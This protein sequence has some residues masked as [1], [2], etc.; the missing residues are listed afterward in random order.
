M[1]VQIERETMSAVDN[2]FNKLKSTSAY[3]SMT[4]DQ[5]YDLANELSKAGMYSRIAGIFNSQIDPLSPFTDENS[6]W[7][8]FTY[9]ELIQ[10]EEM[11][12]LIP[13]EVLAWA[14]SMQDS[15]SINY[16]TPEITNT[17][18]Q[19]SLDSMNT[20]SNASY[21]EMKNN[22]LG[23][24]EKS[25]DNQ[26]DI[27]NEKENIDI[28]KKAAES[29]NMEA[30]AAQNKALSKI[31]NLYK[32]W[33]KLQSKIKR[34]T[35]LSESEQQRFNELSTL[36]N[37]ET[38]QYQNEMNDIDSAIDE[39]AESL[40]EIDEMSAKSEKLSEVSETIGEEITEKEAKH[41]YTSTG[42]NGDNTTGIMGVILSGS[43][44]KNLAQTILGAAI[45]T[46]NSTEDMQLEVN[47]VASINDLTTN[48]T[49]RAAEDSQ[50]QNQVSDEQT[51]QT[52][53]N[54]KEGAENDVK[55]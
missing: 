28:S 27:E 25:K 39:I 53:N 6:V 46:D 54:V 15:D 13:E 17:D 55:V 31:E 50:A 32:E 5:L 21:P 42:K 4:D 36:L 38:K 48:V 16:E 1:F 8:Q 52:I 9:T 12:V 41:K 23:M 40:N 26:N 14:H 24:V 7:A 22:A 10:M 47:E 37:N 2:I 3:G 29:K 34:G 18:D 45:Q 49:T 20:S 44:S 51:E 33:E 43:L 11:G 19:T 30:E 35:P